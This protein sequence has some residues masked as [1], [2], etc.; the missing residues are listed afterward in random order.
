MLF[1]GAGIFL[2]RFVHDLPEGFRTWIHNPSF[3]IPLAKRAVA[4]VPI[5][6]T[7]RAPD[8]VP[9]ALPSLTRCSPGFRRA[10]WMLHEPVYSL[11]GRGNAALIPSNDR[12][13]LTVET[14][15]EPEGELVEIGL[16]MLRADA[17]VAASEP[18]FQIA[19][20]QMGDRQKSSA[21]W[22]ALRATAD[23][24]NRIGKSYSRQGRT[25]RSG[26]AASTNPQTICRR[27]ARLPSVCGRHTAVA[28]GHQ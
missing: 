27:S 10:F 26:D 23:A 24:D 19:E 11:I 12:N 1:F 4:S 8:L 15:I 9:S 20:D 18:A 13:A 6:L 3:I 28:G 2:S 25:T 7:P 17:V 14:A 5:R 16:Q 22:D 21:R